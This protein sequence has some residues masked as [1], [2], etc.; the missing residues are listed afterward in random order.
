[1]Q[2]F[3]G[4]WMD[5]DQ[6]VAITLEDLKKESLEVIES[7][8]EHYHFRGGSRSRGVPYGPQETVSEKT[9]QARKK[10]QLNQF[11]EQVIDKVK[12][13]DKLYVFGPADTKTLFADK[14]KATY[15]MQD[16]ILKVETADTMTQNQMKERVR[17]LFKPYW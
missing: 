17:N 12:D 16:K 3:I 10:Q 4:I 13:A 8:V 2:K 6:A 7:G 9:I 5:S 11:F 1:M 14:I 15:Q